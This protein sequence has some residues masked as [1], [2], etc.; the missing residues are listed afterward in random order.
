MVIIIVIRIII[1]IIII[2]FPGVSS[3]R[4][5]QG[6]SWAWG[7]RDRGADLKFNHWHLCQPGLENGIAE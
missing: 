6:P 1:I 5:L 4:E 2:T 7:D 3:V